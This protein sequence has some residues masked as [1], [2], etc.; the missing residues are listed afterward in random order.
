[1]SGH[2]RSSDKIRKCGSLRRRGHVHRLRVSDDPSFFGNAACGSRLI[3]RQHHGVNA[4]TTEG[5]NHWPHARP[6]RIE[7]TDWQKSNQNDESSL[8]AGPEGEGRCLASIHYLLRMRI[9]VD[10]L[11]GQCPI[12][13]REAAAD[14]EC[15]GCDG[16][17]SL[18]CLT[19]IG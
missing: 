5:L 16:R 18:S 14:E 1:M 8:V 2:V 7:R 4:G 12:R 13:Q 19:S 10:A 3:A 11:L 15:G 6:Q 17:V 9:I